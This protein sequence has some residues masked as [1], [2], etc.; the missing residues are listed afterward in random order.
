[1]PDIKYHFAL[2]VDEV[3]PIEKVDKD[4]RHA[5]TYTCIGCG[6]EMIARIGQH[7]VPHF[8]HKVKGGENCS[9]ETYLHK[10]AK[11]LI[12][13]KFESPEPLNIKY[14]RI[15][16]CSNIKTCPFCKNEECVVIQPEVYNL[17]KYYNSCQ[18]ENP[19]NGFIADI[20]LTHSAFPERDPVLIEVQFTHKSTVEKLQSGLRIIEI[21]VSSEDNIKDLLR[22]DVL[23][24]DLDIVRN[25]ELEDYMLD[26]GDAKFYNFD[27]TPNKVGQRIIPRYILYAS[28][29]ARIDYENDC[30]TV[31]KKIDSKSIFEVSF[32]ATE[33]N[34]FSYLL[35]IGNVIACKHIPDF[36]TCKLCKFYKTYTDMFWDKNNVCCLYK[37]YNTPRDPLPIYAKQCQYFSPNYT[38]IKD[39][40]MVIPNYVVATE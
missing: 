7:N 38:M 2:E 24:E 39:I 29:K 35:D 30:H 33:S 25:P 1:M 28:G 3:I 11:R 12:R 23:E 21:K 34:Y 40:K 26:K 32:V 4:E 22:K 19:I 14:H 15:G 16:T 10:L 27:R 20:L 17:K 9:G 37:K 18:E 6:A 13:E 36:K 31:K 5:H 8:A